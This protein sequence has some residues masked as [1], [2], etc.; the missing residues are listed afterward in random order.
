MSLLG[1]E[2]NFHVVQRKEKEKELI[3]DRRGWVKKLAETAVSRNTDE[4]WNECYQ[5]IAERIVF[6]EKLRELE[7]KR[8]YRDPLTGIPNR[9]F[10]DEVVN[11]EM[12]RCNRRGTSYGVLIVD[13][14]YFKK[15]NDMYGHNAGDYVLRDVAKRIRDAIRAEDLCARYGGEE[16]SVLLPEPQ[17]SGLDIVGQR[18][19]LAI[20]E[21]EFIVVN[22]N[23]QEVQANITVS[24]GGTLSRPHEKSDYTIARADKALYNS[25]EAGRNLVTID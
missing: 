16:F 15:V 22:M 11:R 23:K 2:K 20:Q 5:I 19:R 25:K 24:V 17:L 8:G 1:E 9:R 3:N 12:E 7:K 6:L 14:D 13:V 4:A 21:N 10:W 18:I